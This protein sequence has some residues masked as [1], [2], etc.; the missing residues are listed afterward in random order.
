MTATDLATMRRLAAPTV[1]PDGRWAVYQLRETDLEGNRG[2]TDLWLL[3]LNRRGA[4]PVRIASALEHNEH[5]PRFSAD[6]RSLYFLTNASGSSNCGASR[7]R[8][9]LPYRSPARHRHCR[10]SARAVGRPDRDLGR[11]QHRV[12]RLQLRERDRAGPGHGSGRVYDETF[13]RHWDTWAEP[14][15][16]SRIFTFRSSMASAGWRHAGGAE[17]LGDSPSKPFG[18][19]EELAWSPDGRT[20]YFTLRE[21]GRD[22]AARPISTSTRCPA[23]PAPPPVNLTDAN[24]ATDVLPAVSPDGRWLAYV[25]MARP[26]YEADRQVVQLRNLR[27]ARPGADRRLGPLG[28]SLAWAADSRS[29][30]VTAGEVL[31]TPLFRVD[32]RSGR[33]TRLTRAGTVAIS[34]A[35][36]GSV[37]VHSEQ[38]AARRMTSTGSTAAAAPAGSPRS[39]PTGSPISIR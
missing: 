10:L 18:G 13:V 34:S 30:Y 39:M 21:G 3:D 28:R 9:E 16:R 11:P 38:P 35:R 32:V 24:E 17:P 37:R 27:P 1:S 14:G 19:A 5:D 29:L 31:D 2:R 36:D 22:R 23:T 7:C 8:P 33:A 25:A 15:V 12:Q 20:L 4:Q 26:T 6:G